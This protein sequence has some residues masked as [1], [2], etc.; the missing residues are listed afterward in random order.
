MAACHTLCK[1]RWEPGSY[2]YHG[3]DGHKFHGQGHGEEYGPK[4]GT[5]DTVGAGVHMGRQE[6]FFT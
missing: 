3:D 1:C 2:G 4:F 5:G 6:M